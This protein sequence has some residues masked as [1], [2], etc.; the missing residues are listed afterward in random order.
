MPRIG[1]GVVEQRGANEGEAEV[2][3]PEHRSPDRRIRR[4]GR[5]T[6][7][8]A[9]DVCLELGADDQR[10]ADRG[11]GRGDSVGET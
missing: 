10:G 8:P 7:S 9:T 11:R 3:T 1:G 4:R 2:E 5:G 6:G